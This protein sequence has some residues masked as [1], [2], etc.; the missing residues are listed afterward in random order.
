MVKRSRFKQ[1]SRF[2]FT[3]MEKKKFL[4]EKGDEGFIRISYRIQ[5]TNVTRLDEEILSGT[6]NLG[7]PIWKCNHVLGY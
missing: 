6:H 2:K 1:K 3:Q 4:S 7:Y 5:M